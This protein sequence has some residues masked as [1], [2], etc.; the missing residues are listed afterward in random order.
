MPGKEGTNDERFV[1]VTVSLGGEDCQLQTYLLP[2][3]IITH[4]NVAISIAAAPVIA[5]GLNWDVVQG[6]R[7]STKE[8]MQAD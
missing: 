8:T 7:E 1:T 4:S 2:L 3:C 6:C 5:D